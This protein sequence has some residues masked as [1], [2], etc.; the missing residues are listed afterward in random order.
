M[1][2]DFSDIDL[3]EDIIMERSMVY[4]EITQWWNASMVQISAQVHIFLSNV[5]NRVEM[6]VYYCELLNFEKNCM[7]FR[8]V[9]TTPI[10]FRITRCLSRQG[11]WMQVL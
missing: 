4:A 7:T 8:I 3:R 6:K 9:Y 1:N 10:E 2:V 5:L 11:N